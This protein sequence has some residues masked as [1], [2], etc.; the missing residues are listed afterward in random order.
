MSRCMTRDEAAQ[1]IGISVESFDAWRRKGILPGPIPNTHRWDRKALDLA[2]DRAS[3]LPSDEGGSVFDE[4]KRARSPARN[5]HG[6]QTP[7]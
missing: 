7:R 1:H 6:D 2:L 5:Q 4:W 3:G